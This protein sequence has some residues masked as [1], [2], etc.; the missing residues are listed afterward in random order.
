MIIY[1]AS[2]IYYLARYRKITIESSD[3]I[4]R[5]AL[6]ALFVDSLF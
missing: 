1:L 6:I 5:V 4:I 2:I 3:T